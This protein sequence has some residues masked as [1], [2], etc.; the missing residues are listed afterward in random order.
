MTTPVFNRTRTRIVPNLSGSNVVLGKIYP[1]IFVDGIPS[2][3]YSSTPSQTQVYNYLANSR[4]Q[5]AQLCMDTMHEG[6]PYRTGDDFTVLSYDWCIPYVGI[7]GNGTF[8]RADKLAQYVGGFHPSPLFSPNGVL[9]EFSFANNSN[10]NLLKKV[11]NVNIPSLAGLGEQAWKRTKPKLQKANAAVFGAELRDMPRMLKSTS[12][13]FHNIW[14]GMGGYYT[15]VSESAKGAGRLMQPKKVADDFLNQQFGWVPFIQDLLKFNTVVTD[16]HQIIAKL[17][18]RNDRWVRRRVP[19]RG[20]SIARVVASGTA[21][22][23]SPVTFHSSYFTTTPTWSVSEVKTFTTSAVGKFRFYRPEFDINAQDELSQWNSAMQFITVS[24]LRPTPSNVYKA[25][26]WTWL[27]DWF[28]NVGDYVEHL[29][30]I[31][32]DSVV[33]Q[34]CFAMQHVH[35]ERTFVQELP[36]VAGGRSLEFRRVIDSKQRITA[37]SPYGFS[38]SWDSLSP[39]QLAILAA[40]GIVRRSPI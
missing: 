18:N 38:L 14:K 35:T 2:G 32:V 7:H 20:E 23:C 25:V 24:G 1:A 3:R 34:Y 17:V 31:W 6:P 4:F 5:R 13:R 15:S 9:D 16:Y 12:K 39:T 22:H 26:P 36:F 28:S 11:D 37:N 29:N 19:L 27:I 8:P 33:S 21:N 40:L 10:T 30:D